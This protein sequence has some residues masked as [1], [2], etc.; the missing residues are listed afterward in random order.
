MAPPISTIVK[1]S[2]LPVS[3]FDNLDQWTDTAVGI[4]MYWGEFS[5]WHA[6]CLKGSVRIA[7]ATAHDRRNSASSVARPLMQKTPKHR[8]PRSLDLR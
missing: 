3:Q 5:R 1:T 4:S 6:N 2:P 8:D 7:S